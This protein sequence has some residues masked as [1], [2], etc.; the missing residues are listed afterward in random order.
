MCPGGACPPGSGGGGGFV[1]P[2]PQRP[3]LLHG[4]N[5]PLVAGVWAGVLV[6]TVAVVLLRRERSKR[7]RRTAEAA[8]AEL[9]QTGADSLAHFDPVYHPPPSPAAT[10]REMLRDF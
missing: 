3:A 7:R 1:A 5:L 4:F 10:L 8:A 6:L 2:T 9:G